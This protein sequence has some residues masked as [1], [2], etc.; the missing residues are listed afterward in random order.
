MSRRR[1]VTVPESMAQ[2]PEITSEDVAGSELSELAV[3]L[4]LI[5]NPFYFLLWEGS[6][7]KRGTDQRQ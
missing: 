1:T 5:I 4:G 7:V 3:E 6:L 2:R